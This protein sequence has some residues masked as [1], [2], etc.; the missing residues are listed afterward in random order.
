MKYIINLT[1]LFLCFILCSCSFQTSFFKEIN[2]NLINKNIITSPLS[3]YQVIGLTSNGA[4]D[5]TLEQ[6]LLALENESLEELNNINVEILK[7]SK[8]FTTI[9]IANAI[10]TTFNPKEKFLNAASKYESSVET[11]KSVAQV[12]N[13]CNL[14]THGKIE[15]ILDELD[16][17]TVMILLNAIYFKG[18]WYTEFPENATLTTNFYNFNDESK[19]AKVDMMSIKDYFNYY[20][21]KEMQII[22]LPYTKDSMSAIIILPNEDIEINDYISDL[23][24]DKLQKL[25]KKCIKKKLN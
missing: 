4:N 11:L 13:W 3:A 25:M 15:K 24:D 14:K 20:E 19:V 21:D 2:K 6:M 7:T 18:T 12:N 23:N 1:F 10:M 5:K 22:E 8:D 16:P 17:N 9:E